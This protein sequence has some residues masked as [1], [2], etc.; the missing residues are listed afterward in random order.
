MM[1]WKVDGSVLLLGFGAAGRS[2]RVT[3]RAAEFLGGDL[4]WE[5]GDADGGSESGQESSPMFWGEPGGWFGRARAQDSVLHVW[6][7]SPLQPP[8]R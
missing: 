2:A 3:F 6:V 7:L 4:G 5:D 1:G 8:A